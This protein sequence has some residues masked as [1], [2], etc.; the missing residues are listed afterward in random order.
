MIWV[1]GKFQK[2][3][4]KSIGLW[5]KS[6]Q[7]IHKFYRA[8]WEYSPIDKSK[9]EILRGRAVSHS[10]STLHP[11][12]RN[13]R[14]RI[15]GRPLYVVAAR[16]RRHRNR[17]APHTLDCVVLVLFIIIIII[18][19]IISIAIDIDIPLIVHTLTL[20]SFLVCFEP[21]LSSSLFML[22]QNLHRALS[23]Q[24]HLE[25]VS[26]RIDEK[27]RATKNKTPKKTALT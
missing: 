16:S 2:R 1:S 15:R 23:F 12:S 14:P 19:I 4:T 5:G 9:T 6:S 7:N 18:V 26:S 21:S 27:I 8:F 13:S 20:W 10:S 24:N 3:S 25:I 22:H 11:T 17:N